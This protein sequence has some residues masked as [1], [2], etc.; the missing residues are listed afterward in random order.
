MTD[1]EKISV[2]TETKPE[3]EKADLV[4]KISFKIIYYL[5]LFLESFF[6]HKF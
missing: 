6:I 2:K 1:S 3:E 5:N 4:R